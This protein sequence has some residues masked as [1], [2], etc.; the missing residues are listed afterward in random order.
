MATIFESITDAPYWDL[1]WWV[2]RKYELRG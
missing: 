2:A 1:W